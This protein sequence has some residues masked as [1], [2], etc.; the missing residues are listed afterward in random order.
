MSP[1][2]RRRSTVAETAADRGHP[3]RQG[4]LKATLLAKSPTPEQAIAAYDDVAKTNDPYWRALAS[5][6]ASRPGCGIKACPPPMPSSVSMPCATC[7]GGT[8]WSCNHADAGQP[9]CRP[10]NFTQGL[11]VLQELMDLAR[12]PGS[13]PGEGEDYRGRQAGLFAEH[14]GDYSPLDV[15]A[16]YDSTAAI[17]PPIPSPASILPAC[18]SASPMWG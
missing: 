2:C 4:L 8:T 15:L 13:H 17:L 14:G 10:G 16:V 9:L 12:M 5:S 7:G 6:L 18:P 1:P 3:I 11:P